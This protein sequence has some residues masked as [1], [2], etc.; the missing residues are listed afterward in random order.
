M[1][2]S[3]VLTVR[4]KLLTPKV[5]ILKVFIHR[6]EEMRVYYVYWTVHHLDS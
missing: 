6:N 4:V 3:M 1:L 5:V 2:I